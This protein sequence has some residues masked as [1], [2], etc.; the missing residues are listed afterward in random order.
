MGIFKSILSRVLGFFFG[1]D[2]DIFDDKGR[3]RHKLPSQTWQR[4]HD[5]YASDPKNNWRHHAG[6]QVRRKL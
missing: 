4:W 6:T 3:V 5:R 2:P 1:K